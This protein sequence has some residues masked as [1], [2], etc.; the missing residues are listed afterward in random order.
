MIVNH[1][2]LYK[3]N[4]IHSKKRLHCVFKIVVNSPLMFDPFVWVVNVT[5]YFMSYSLSILKYFP[6][7][8][9]IL[10]TKINFTV[11]IYTFFL[12]VGEWHIKFV[13]FL[14]KTNQL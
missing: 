1:F 10:K 8:V 7:F 9:G 5:S 6:T 14:L 3:R 2:F 13:S 12:N 4:V 11:D